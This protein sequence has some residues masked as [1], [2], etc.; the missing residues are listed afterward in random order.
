MLGT[1]IVGTIVT[2]L[3]IFAFTGISLNVTHAQQTT[4]STA[5]WPSNNYDLAMSR[6]S[7]QTTINAGNVNQLVEKWVFNASAPVEN[8]PLIVGNTAYAQNN[9]EQVF[10]I[11]MSTGKST[12]TFDPH[13]N[14]TDTSSHGMTY[15]NG[16]IYAPTGGNDTVVA[17]NA[18]DGSLI[19]QSPQT[20][21]LYDN[22]SP[23]VVWNNYIIV[24]GAGGDLPTNAPP[25][26]GTVVA[27]DKTNGKILWQLNTT[28]GPWIEGANASIN[29]G[30]AVWSGGSVDPD[31]GTIYLPV[32]N[33]APDFNASTRQGNSSY[34]GDVIAVNIRNGNVVWAT[35]LVQVGNTLGATVPDTHDYDAAWGTNLVSAA[36]SNG[37]QKLVIGHDKRGDVLAMDAATGRPLWS[38]NLAYLY[39]DGVPPS[40]NG[41][42]EVWVGTQSGIEAYTAADQNTVYAADSNTAVNF[43]LNT[44]NGTFGHEK[45]YFDAMPNGIGNGTIAALD[46]ANGQI[47]W[48]HETST[49]TWVSPL[50][51]NDVLFA[52]NITSTGKP[53]SYN[54]FA[55]PTS[56]PLNVTGIIKALDKNTGQVLWQKDTRVP[57]PIG[58]G[59]PSIGNGMLLVPIGSPAEIPAY[60]QGYV[61][62]YGLPTAPT[63]APAAAKPTAPT[64][65]QP[66]TCAAVQP[67]MP[68]TNVQG[69]CC[70]EVYQSQQCCQVYNNQQQY[71]EIYQSQQC[72]QVYSY[73]QYY[74]IYQTL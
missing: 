57:G 21:P 69:Q 25:A 3:I 37:A 23:P 61:V 33:A 48:R 14:S 1:K 70:Y 59:G 31:T 10:A 45:P 71:Y 28:V 53:Y 60:T 47:K 20:S 63:A 51:T 19:W 38:N 35:P 39:R 9:N 67:T 30:G 13:Q 16:I 2:L 44:T 72:C 41:S 58:I 18:S 17:L 24:G 4:A 36:T 49:P 8:T 55:A 73:Q 54:V 56:T 40:V 7:P 12:W 68:V 6:N 66:T 32:G 26:K 5:D 34:T 43:F 65:A 15:E 27:L 46:S 42:G 64:A 50:V 22:P 11:N 52:G 62:A 29:G 74:Q